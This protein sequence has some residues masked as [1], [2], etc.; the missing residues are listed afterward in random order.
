MNPT[1]SQYITCPNS[2][3]M[4]PGTLAMDLTIPNS[5]TSNFPIIS[6]NST[7]IWIRR[8]ERLKEIKAEEEYNLDRV[9]R[10]RC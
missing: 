8:K 1:S 2:P 6:D 5:H 3:H 4:N 10:T 7:I 9:K